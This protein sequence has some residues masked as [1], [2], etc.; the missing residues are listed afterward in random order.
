MSR[1]SLTAALAVAA[2]AALS[3]AGCS[4]TPSSAA[5]TSGGGAV[6]NVAAS[7]NAWGSILAQL[8]GSHV[9]ATSIIT[10]PDTDPHDYEPT[11]ADGRVI[12]SSKLF[13]ENGIGYDAWADRAVQ[14]SPDSARQVIDVGPLTGT[15]VGGNPHRWY[16]PSD[17]SKVADAITADLT[18]IDPADAGYFTAQRSAF[19]NTALA[20]YHRLITD[21]KTTYAGTPVGASESIFAP[22]A[23]ALGLDL[24]TPASFLKDISEGTDPSAADKATIDAQI[25]SKKIK[26]YVYNSQ[27]STPDVSAQ[28]AAAKR[29]GIPV[30]SVTET[31]SPAGAS[32]QDWQS[33]Q[34]RSL[35]A[36]LAKAAG[37]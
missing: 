18:K 12:A 29:Q 15:P 16:S 32:F 36:A 35:E 19:E 5:S 22:L 4:S 28:V 33:A 3:L 25:S 9:K 24:I 1:R 6:I 11:P 34:L 23:D 10:N 8:G 7:I 30:A 27:N 13:V 14:A 17:V 26:V 37:K 31:L 2:L 21:I 20:Q